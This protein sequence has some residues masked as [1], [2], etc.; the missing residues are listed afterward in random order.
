MSAPSLA[1]TETNLSRIVFCIRQMLEG[2]SNAVG[3]VTLS[4]NATSTTVTAL[5]GADSAVFL[6]PQ[7]ASAAG[8]ASTVWIAKSGIGQGRFTV[9]HDSTAATDRSFWFVALG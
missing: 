5:C 3:Q 6:F 2:R 4:P 9:S 1:P 7:T 8:S